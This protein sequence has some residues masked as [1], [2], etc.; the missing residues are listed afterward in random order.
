MG[1]LSQ[2]CD[3]KIFGS[4]YNKIE[5]KNLNPGFDKEKF[6]QKQDIVL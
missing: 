6:C 5:N 2:V 4:I 3:K 1:W